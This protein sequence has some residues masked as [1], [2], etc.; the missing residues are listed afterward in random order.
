MKRLKNWIRRLSIRKKLVFY[1]YLVITPILLLISGILFLRNYNSAVEEE[2]YNC[3]QSIERLSDS[4]EVMQKNIMEMGTY[5]CINNEITK[6]LTSSTPDELNSDAQ[7]WIHHA[8]LQ[9]IQ[10]MLAIDG[11]IKTVA[12][13]PENGVEPYLRCMDYSS[14]IGD[15][16]E[17]RKEDIY[18]L[19]VQEKGQFLWQRVGK[20]QSDTYQ[21]NQNDKIVMYREIYDLA[22]KN[23]LGY[24]VIGSSAENF[25]R[26]CQNSMRDENEAVVAMSKYGSILVSCGSMDE[27]FLTGAVNKLFWQVNGNTVSG[28]YDYQDNRVYWC[29]SEETGTVIFKIVPKATI[30]DFVDSIIIVPLALLLGVLVGLYPVMILVSNIVSKPLHTLGIAMQNFKRGDFSQKVEVM[31]S[32]EVGEA[33]ACFN[34]MVDD[35]RNLI[36]KNYVMALKERESELDALQAQINPHFLYNT[37]D[38]LYWKA[39]EAGDE[40]IAEDIFSLSQLFRLVLS[41]GNSIVTVKK[42]AELVERYLH[43]QKM[44]FGK[45][46]EYKILMNES[47]LSE[48]IPKLILQPFVE[49]AIVHGFEQGG[50]NFFLSIIGE[51][52]DDHMAFYICDTGVGMSDEQ[53]E[54][55]WKTEESKTH[56]SQQ[57]GKY[58]IKN[59]KERLELIYHDEYKLDIESREGQGTTVKI[60]VPCGLKEMR[61]HE[62]KTVDSGR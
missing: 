52:A 48:E 1:T 12:I 46:L 56:S 49:N 21:F 44:R 37:L 9:I 2:E 19:A 41:R 57:I 55:I 51:K 40:E 30:L 42:E 60:V 47:I 58:A 22:R 62:H 10:D 34:S 39:I 20:Y 4:F 23:K 14:Y 29:K 50:C 36:N 35:I 26:M 61:M 11:Q 16:A 38:S 31:T 15:V 32:D 53:L 28:G 33:S 5:I 7:L 18:K 3:L 59:V 8:P 17:V 13:Y 6:I 27:E 24:L 25:D 43:I 45:R 54:A